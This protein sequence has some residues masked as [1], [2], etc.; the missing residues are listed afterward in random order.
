MKIASP[1]YKAPIIVVIACTAV[2]LSGCSSFDWL[3]GRGKNKEGQ[4]ERYDDAP[5]TVE[6]GEIPAD[7]ANARYSETE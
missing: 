5:L 6:T 4:A 1:L 7:S 2:I 3:T